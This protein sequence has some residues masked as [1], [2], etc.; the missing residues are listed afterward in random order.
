M[1]SAIKIYGVLFV[2]IFMFIPFCNSNEVKETEIKLSDVPSEIMK[3]AEN[4]VPEA[5]FSSANTEIDDGSTVYEIQGFLEDGRKFEIDIYKDGKIQEI[6]IVFTKDLVPGAVLKA[7]Q[8]RY[9]GF[10]PTFIEASHS[11]SKKVVKYEF[12]GKQNDRQLDLEVSADGREIVE[13]DK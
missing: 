6:E 8:A 9:P 3:Q 13:S 4:V 2:G 10:V 7:I 5:K 1:N 11:A 12:V